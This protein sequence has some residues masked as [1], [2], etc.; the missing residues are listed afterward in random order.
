MK[1]EQICRQL[2]LYMLSSAQLNPHLGKSLLPF[3]VC[4]AII[5]IEANEILPNALDYD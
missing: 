2:L 5:I 1:N 4:R 3:R